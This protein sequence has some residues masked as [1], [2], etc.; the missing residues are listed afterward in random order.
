MTSNEDDGFRLWIVVLLTALFCLLFH[1]CG[2][3]TRTEQKVEKTQHETTAIDCIIPFPL[4]TAT[5]LQMIDIPIHL[6]MQRDLSE[7]ASTVGTKDSKLVVPELANAIAMAIKQFAP[8]LSG[9]LPP[10]ATDHTAAII[11]AVSTLSVGLA[12][13]AKAKADGKTMAEKD[14]Q[15]EFHKS[16]A[17][18]AYVALRATRA[19]GQPI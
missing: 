1:G 4:L 9:L 19:P 17:E 7:D 18:E 14:K 13:L 11:G 5:G 2:F 12:A 15:I 3:N 8:G 10:P 16:D 6:T